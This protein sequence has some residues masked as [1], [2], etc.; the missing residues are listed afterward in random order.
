[1]RLVSILLIA[2]V[3]DRAFAPATAKI[4]GREIIVSSFQVA[5]PVVVRYGFAPNPRCNLVGG[6]GLP[7]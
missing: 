4:E 6:A 1:M 5:K 3:T 2:V 7:V